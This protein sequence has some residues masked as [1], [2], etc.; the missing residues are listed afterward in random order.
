[1]RVTENA[2]TMFV[3]LAKEQHAGQ[4]SD[5]ILDLQDAR[6]AIQEL[7]RWDWITIVREV[8]EMPSDDKD[9]MLADFWRLRQC[10]EGK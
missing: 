1:M 10:V 6:T 5:A 2:L 8:I 7:L 4:F 3:A 9:E